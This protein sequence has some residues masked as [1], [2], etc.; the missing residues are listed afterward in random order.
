MH[1]V[2]TLGLK[3]K[4]ENIKNFHEIA[5]KFLNSSM[6]SSETFHITFL[7]ID[8]IDWCRNIRAMDTAWFMLKSPGLK[9]DRFD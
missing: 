9:S 7:S 4:Q 5:L 1:F 2:D 8:G 6:P 3:S